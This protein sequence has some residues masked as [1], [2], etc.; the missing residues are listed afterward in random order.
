M[1]GGLLNFVSE[2]NSNVILNGNPGKSFFKKKYAK[3]TNFGMQK[4]RLD[5]SGSRSLRLSQDSFFTFDI[6]RFGDLLMDTYFVFNLPNI[7]SPVVEFNTVNK[8]EINENIREINENLRITS[9]EG[10]IIQL[11]N[12]INRNKFPYEFKWIDNIGSQIIRKIR[13]IIGNQVITEFSGQYLYSQVQRDFSETKRK[14]FDEMTGNTKELND[15]ANFGGRN[16]VYPNTIYNEDWLINAE[17]SLRARKIYVPIN[18]W[19]TLQSK[20]SIPIINLFKNILRIEVVCRP[21]QDLYVVKYIPTNI[22]ANNYNKLSAFLFNNSFLPE[23]INST[24]LA[25]L[26]ES[27][28]KI[29][30]Y[31]QPN[32]DDS[33]YNINRFINRL[34]KPKE[35]DIENFILNNTFGVSTIDNQI[36]N[37]TI[38]G[39][40]D[41]NIFYNK[42]ENNWDADVHLMATYIFLSSE[43]RLNFLNNTKYLLTQIKEQ[44][45]LGLEKNKNIE[46]KPNG[47][48]KSWMWFFQRSDINLRNEWSN[49]TNWLYSSLPYKLITSNLKNFNTNLTNNINL[50]TNFYDIKNSI[51]SNSSSPSSFDSLKLK[52]ID[53]YLINFINLNLFSNGLFNNDVKPR[54]QLIPPGDKALFEFNKKIQLIDNLPNPYLFTGPLHIE[55]E[56]TIFKSLGIEFGGKVRENRLQREVYEY[57]D[58]YT[59]SPG[60][61]K[62]GLY[63]YSFTLNTDPFIYQPKGGININNFSKIDLDFQLLT[64]NLNP[65]ATNKVV[66]KDNFNKDI[67]LELN[68]N[69]LLF[70]NNL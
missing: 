48:L 2:G 58:I 52:N 40:P 68:T 5:V 26:V 70:I 21:I 12:I 61:G 64:T 42:I 69:E 33:V 67:I 56:K 63:S 18:I 16:N 36:K 31:I 11:I 50:N 13:F 10:Q 65:N 30:T 29:N 51:Y 6:L 54:V 45:Y 37:G 32:Q 3:Y 1:G 38:L 24:I 19:S 44:Q 25:D 27:T 9:T 35:E 28:K 62:E 49:Y 55:N 39:L 53:L 43:E 60:T 4:F 14:L 47:L 34:S 23:N 41:D 17:P 15:P 59:R 8:F 7:W 57:M 46:I 22:E 66:F 20:L